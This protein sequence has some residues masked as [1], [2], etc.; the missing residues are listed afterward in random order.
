MGRLHL[1]DNSVVLELGPGPGCFSPAV[2]HRL[3]NGRLILVD[4]QREMLGMAR[5]SLNHAGVT[6]FALVQGDGMAL[7]LGDSTF[8]AVFLV[9]VLGETSD[10]A[11]CVREIRRVLRPGGLFSNTEQP[12][13]PDV[14]P[15]EKVV[16]L[17]EEVGLVLVETYGQGKNYTANF[18]LS[19]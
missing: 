19:T 8:D 13:D 11:G 5:D 6:S 18:R 17:A 4:V 2:A 16:T 9:A 12:G 10:P 14:L 7:P 3:P 1:G 15:A